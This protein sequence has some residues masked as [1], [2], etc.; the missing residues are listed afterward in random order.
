[1]VRHCAAILLFL[2]GGSTAFGQAW[3]EKM[4]EDKS[5]DFGSVARGARAVHEFPFTNLYLED[6]H[7]SSAR[8]SCGCTSVTIKQPSLKTHQ[9]GAI[10]AT[11][12]SDR[13]LGRRAATITVTIDRPYRARVFLKVA[14]YVH[15]DVE[16]DPR[17]AEF[18]SVDQGTAVDRTVRLRYTGRSGLEIHEIRSSNASLSAEVIRHDPSRRL[19]EL[20]VHLDETAPV[21]PINEHLI[22]V[23][24]HS[25]FREIPLPVGGSVVPDVIVSPRDIFLGVL[26]PGERVTKQVIVR[27]KTPFSITRVSSDGPCMTYQGPPLGTAAVLHVIPVTFTADDSQGTVLESLRIQTDLNDKVYEVRGHAVVRAR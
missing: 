9:S 22:L 25:R 7:I 27:G 18:G 6:I 3:A 8:P 14:A 11:L 17:A 19:Y 5:H 16:L 10:V 21:G 4:F 24:N 23:T 1:M 12:N 2:V 26:A 13:Y 20:R 15:R